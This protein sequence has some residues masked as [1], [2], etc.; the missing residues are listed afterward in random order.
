MVADVGECKSV[1]PENERTCPSPIAKITKNVI[2]I[3]CIVIVLIPATVSSHSGEG[4]TT[5]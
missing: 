4:L 3:W 2:E 1:T 5:S